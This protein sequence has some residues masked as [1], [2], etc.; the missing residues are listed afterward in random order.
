MPP[1]VPIIYLRNPQFL[2]FCV[3]LFSCQHQFLLAEKNLVQIRTST[4]TCLTSNYLFV[5]SK[6]ETWIHEFTNFKCCK[7]AKEPFNPLF[8][9]VLFLIYYFKNHFKPCFS[10]LKA[11]K[12]FLVSN[13]LHWPQ[14]LIP[15]DL[16]CT[17]KQHSSV[18]L[19][20]LLTL[21]TYLKISE[22]TNLEFSWFFS[23]YLAIRGSENWKF[24]AFLLKIKL[25]DTRKF[26]KKG[27]V[28][29]AR[30]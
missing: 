22:T 16:I 9:G 26:V 29:V 27:L 19:S 21:N 18:F 7:K 25:K 2:F 10:I 5:T 4:L 8:N 6:N 13:L 17:A 30:Y 20:I 3:I 15:R 23:G 11:F 24:L 14:R 1:E 12:A 28:A